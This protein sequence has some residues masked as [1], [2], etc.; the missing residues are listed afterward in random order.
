MPTYTR[1]ECDAIYRSDILAFTRKAFFSLFPNDPYSPEWFHESIALTLTQSIRRPMRQIINAPPRSLKSNLVSVAWVAFRLGQDP[2]HKFICASYSQ[3][4]ATTLSADCRRIMES[5]WYQNL[6]STRLAKS[7]ED[8]LV[9][10]KGGGRLAMSVGGTCTGLGAHTIIVDDPLN[11]AGAASDASR[12]TCNE[13]FDRSL[14]S[15]LNDK[16]RGSIF[17]VMQRLHQQDLTGHLIEKGG[18][19]HLVLPAIAPDDRTIQLQNRSLIWAEGEPLQKREPLPVLDDVKRQVGAPVFQTQYLQDPAPDQG[20][21]LKRE[22]L[23]SYDI[24]PS[25]LPGDEIVLSHRSL[26]RKG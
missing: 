23:K 3:P 26:A 15:R 7:T 6:F 2:T 22:W 5:A 1:A 14:M 12:K 21:E 11:A 4:L 24:L 19:D 17:V 25:R 16:A 9:T 20:N 8:E 13:W 10:T 18:W